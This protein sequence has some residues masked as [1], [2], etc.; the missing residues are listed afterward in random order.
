MAACSAAVG[1]LSTFY[2]DSLDPR[3]ARHVEISVHRLIAK[4]PTIAAYA[5]K[6]SIG[7][8][9]MYPQ[10]RARTTSANFLHM[11]FATPCEPYDVDPVLAKALD[12]LLIL[13]ADHEQNCSTRTVRLVGSSRRT[14]SRAISAG[15]SAL[16]GP[17]H[18]GAN[19]EVIEM[20]EQIR[21]EGITR[22][23]VRRARQEQGRHRAPDGLRPPRLQELRPAH[24]D[25][26]EGLR[27]R[28]RRS[29]AC[30]RQLLEIAIELEEIAL[31]DD[32]FVERKLY[33]NVDF[34]SGVIYNAI[35]IPANMFTVMFAI[36][37]LPG[38]IAQWMEMHG[39]PD[40]KI[41]RP[42]QI[43]TGP[44]EQQ[45][46]PARQ[47]QGVS[48]DWIWVDGAAASRAPTPSI[49]ADD[50]AFAEGRGCYTGVRIAG[51]RP[52]Y[53]ARHLR[54]LE[55]EARALDLGAFDPELARR[56]LRELGRR[57]AAR[58]RGHRPAPALAR[59]APRRCAWSACRARSATT[60][61][62]GA[63]SARRS[64]TRVRWSP[65]AHKLT[66]RLVHSRSRPT[67]RAP[68]ARTRRC[69]STATAGWSR[70]RAATWSWVDARGSP[71]D[72]AARARRRRGG[73]A[74]AAAASG[75]RCSSSDAD[76]ARDC[77]RRA[78]SSRSTRCA[79]RGRSC[80]S[81]AN[82][83]AT[84]AIP[85]P[86]GSPRRS[87]PTNLA[88]G[89][90][91]AQRAAGERRSENEKSM[92]IE[93]ITAFVTGGASGLGAATARLLAARGARVAI[94]DLPRSKGAELEKE[95]GGAARFL[96][97][98]VTDETQ[99]RGR[100]RRRG[101]RLRPAARAGQLRRHRQRLAHRRQGR[102]ALPAR[103]LH[104][105]DPGQPDRHLQRDPAGGRAHG[106]ERAERG[107]RAR[108][109]RQHRLGRRLRRPDRAGGLLGLQG[110]RGRA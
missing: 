16:W 86:S 104:A 90:S 39:D 72:A 67:R 82:R 40:I 12:L 95:L 59:P 76:L 13:H 74:R 2:P 106:E 20:L 61:R 66:N 101:R 30:A 3:D 6:H 92:Q 89:V 78:P 36:G 37:R 55:R 29:S 103:R 80:G 10:Q 27:R 93:G 70:P 46:R 63:R 9:F 69:S 96:P 105:H 91:R 44:T 58:R 51:G 98:D 56:A 84:P 99:R 85:P 108:R 26:Q 25:H 79:A 32:Y 57:G 83:S 11:M 22:A 109:D 73:R 60:R 4:M 19:Q 31:K 41:G 53:E 24:A 47:A 65:A 71:A 50:S 100:A 1:A 107:R 5:Y 28:A 110:R 62:S 102:R 87:P 64:R 77:A 15:I 97:G 81:T 88:S 34:Y 45:V 52:R 8:P 7:Q 42:R 94:Y 48:A 17:R 14:C 38:W 54:R 68:P 43:Y 35:G 33:P 75:C 21:D 49:P 18:G 23:R